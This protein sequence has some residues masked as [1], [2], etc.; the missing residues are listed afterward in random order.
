MIFVQIGPAQGRRGE[1]QWVTL[2]TVQYAS[3][4]GALNTVPGEFSADNTETQ[5]LFPGSVT[6]DT[7]RIL[8]LEWHGYISMRAAVLICS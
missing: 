5:I 8:P 1:D 2:F 4:G 7:I 6:A 3:A